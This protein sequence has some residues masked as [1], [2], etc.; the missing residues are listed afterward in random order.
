MSRS[1]V[2]KLFDYAADNNG[3]ISL[4]EGVQYSGFPSNEVRIGLAMLL[5]EGYL[6]YARNSFVIPG[7][8][9]YKG[10][11][12]ILL[13]Y[14]SGLSAGK[15]PRRESTHEE[16]AAEAADSA[17]PALPGFPA[18]SEVLGIVNYMAEGS[19]GSR[20][21]AGQKELAERGGNQKVLAFMKRAELLTEFERDRFIMTDK[22][23]ELHADPSRWT[24]LITNLQPAA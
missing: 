6:H 7:P 18:R 4:K 17:Q 14:I 13:E 16:P 1:F 10:R 23:D 5:R 19:E 21:I 15:K 8:E 9:E 2:K 20:Y 11:D 3:S 22:A 12:P 24:S